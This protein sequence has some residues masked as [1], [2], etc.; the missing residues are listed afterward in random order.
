MDLRSRHTYDE[1]VVDPASIMIDEDS[2]DGYDDEPEDKE[3]M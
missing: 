2:D 1:S 3:E